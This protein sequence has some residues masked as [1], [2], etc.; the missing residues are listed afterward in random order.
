MMCSGPKLCGSD[1][2]MWFLLQFI[3]YGPWPKNTHALYCFLNLPGDCS[4]PGSLTLNVQPMSCVRLT[5]SFS[6]AL[7][8]NCGQ[9]WKFS[10]TTAS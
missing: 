3:C 6:L 8:R 10:N 4:P 9:D 7:P 5:K 2:A 1:K